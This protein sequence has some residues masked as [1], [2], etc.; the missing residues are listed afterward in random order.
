M[1]NVSFNVACLSIGRVNNEAVGVSLKRFK[2]TVCTF[3]STSPASALGG[4][5]LL[6]DSSRVCVTFP[7][8]SPASAL[9]G[10]TTK[11][12]E[13]LSNDS[14]RVCVTFRST[15][16]ASALGGLKLLND[17]SRVC[18]RFVQRRLPQHWEG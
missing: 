9:E 18:V 16:P 7:S 8:T 17:S 6:N 12:S 4:L 13:Y 10:L 3:P 2:F 14:S 15:S 11:Q 5:K 1:C